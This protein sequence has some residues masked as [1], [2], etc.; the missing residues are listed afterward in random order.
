GRGSLAPATMFLQG[1]GR[2]P[3]PFDLEARVPLPAAVGQDSNLIGVADRSI[4]RAAIRKDSAPV[5]VVEIRLETR[6]DAVHPE[7]FQ[8]IT[9]QHP[10][11]AT[12][13]EPHQLP[14]PLQDT[15]MAGLLPAIPVDRVGHL[16]APV[17]VLHVV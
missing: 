14:D 6:R 7:E 11:S 5:V 10:G 9:V 13:P 1:R 17:P 2:R 12:G 3:G 16:P 8:F 15:T 4:S